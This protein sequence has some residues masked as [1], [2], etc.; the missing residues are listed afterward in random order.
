MGTEDLIFQSVEETQEDNQIVNER[1][2][3]HVPPGFCRCCPGHR[4]PPLVLFLWPP[5]QGI[6][7]FMTLQSSRFL[8]FCCGLGIYCGVRRHCA[9][10]AMCAGSSHDNF[11]DACGKHDH[12]YCAQRFLEMMDEKR[13]AFRKDLAR[14]HKETGL[15][16]I[17]RLPG[18]AMFCR[19]Q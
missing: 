11:F 13:A 3:D 14:S 9:D 8:I 16:E 4:A 19:A 18:N 12:D 7:A 17:K 6:H 1:L 15:Y 2:E 10:P 5:T